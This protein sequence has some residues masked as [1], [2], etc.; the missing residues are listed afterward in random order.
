[1]S[2][3]VFIRSIGK[4]KNAIAKVK[5]IEGNGKIVINDINGNKYMQY[6]SNLLYI[7]Q[8]PLKVLNL[9]EDFDIVVNCKGGGLSGQADAIK[10][11]VAR[12]LC[13]LSIINRPLLKRHGFLTRN[14][15]V[16]ER[17]KYGLKK[18]RKAPQFSKR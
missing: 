18:A 4:R 14:A 17:K 6:N 2:S 13:K 10:L 16:K 12:S 11:G 15:K 1:M 3:K 8:S 5:L 9:A 7:I